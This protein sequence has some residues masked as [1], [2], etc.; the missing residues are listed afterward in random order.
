MQEIVNYKGLTL[1]KK[2]GQYYIRFLGGQYEEILCDLLITDK[3][4]RTIISSPEKIKNVRDA[5]KSKVPWTKEY[6]TKS[7]LQDALIYMSKMNWKYVKPL[8]DEE[9]IAAFERMT[10]FSLPE[11]FKEC[12]RRYNGARPKYRAFDTDKQTGRELKSFL[13]FN[14]EDKETVWKMYEACSAAYEGRYIPFAIDHFGNLICFARNRQIVFLD[15]ETLNI[16]KIAPS[17]DEFVFSL[18][19]DAVYYRDIDCIDTERE[20]LVR[21]ING[22]GIEYLEKR[23][24][25]WEFCGVNTNYHR[26]LF[27]GEGNN[28]LSS[29]SREEAIRILSSWGATEND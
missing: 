1:I 27:L 23:S 22:Y 15:H 24:L 28:C 14:R 7:A 16:E 6:F 3:E 26:E 9:S 20:R 13:S 19:I 12:V 18:Y 25:K 10:A 17:F 2:L 29:I 21:R 5:Y 11:S 4:A 8:S